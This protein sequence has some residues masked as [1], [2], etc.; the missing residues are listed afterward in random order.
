MPFEN[1]GVLEAGSRYSGTFRQPRYR[2]WRPCVPHS[3]N[4][5]NHR[6]ETFVPNRGLPG[7]SYGGWSDRWRCGRNPIVRN[8]Y[9]K[10]KRTWNR[11][12]MDLSMMW[13]PQRRLHPSRTWWGAW[14]R[15]RR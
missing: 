1:G 5:P 8:S 6:N 2:I 15:G 3:N 7:K 12:S 11:C 9:G 10:Q 13:R 14:C 4:G